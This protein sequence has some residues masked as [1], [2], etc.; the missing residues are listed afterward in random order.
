MIS[1]ETIKAVG[2]LAIVLVFVKLCVSPI[3]APDK[4][5]SDK[6]KNPALR[7]KL[8]TDTKWIC[9]SKKSLDV[10]IL[11]EESY[12]VTSY[13][14]YS[15]TE[16]IHIVGTWDA[17]TFNDNDML[18]VKAQSINLIPVDDT[19]LMTCFIIDQITAYQYTTKR[20][21]S[22]LGKDKL[23]DSTTDYPITC[24]RDR[25]RN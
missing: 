2:V 22:F 17:Y 25:E 3:T 8:I 21:I 20:T 23:E 11:D 7:Q 1:T 16:T 5:P 13:S 19:Q 18:C 24:V 12:A 14:E 10:Q 4:I 6:H 9:K 15:L